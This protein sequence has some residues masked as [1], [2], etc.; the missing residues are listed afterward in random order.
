LDQTTVDKIKVSDLSDRVNI[1]DMIRSVDQDEVTIDLTAPLVVGHRYIIDFGDIRGLTG[2]F[3]FSTDVIIFDVSD[4]KNVQLLPH[5]SDWGFEEE[6]SSIPVNSQFYI[7][8]SGQLDYFNCP[9][10]NAIKIQKGP[11]EEGFDFVVRQAEDRSQIVITPDRPFDI[12]S[13]YTVSISG[14]CDV[15]GALLPDS[16]RSFETSSSPI[17]D[18]IAE[19][20]P[21]LVTG[22]PSGQSVDPSSS[23]SIDFDEPTWVL[24]GE[25]TIA[26][27][28]GFTLK[29]SFIWNPSHTR[30]TFTPDQPFPSN[31][32]IRV[33]IKEKFRF[34]DKTLIDRAGNISLPEN[35]NDKYLL[36][37]SFTIGS[38]N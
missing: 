3:V 22:V 20:N 4:S 12:S 6:A 11:I 38:A 8:I 16:T 34:F 9:I 24:L 10:K 33:R 21:R 15:S 17:F 29:G 30:V 27:S 35:A 14:L 18:K 31:R 23:I 2:Q 5:V 28:S 26:I 25:N 37:T 13:R 19:F 7:E 32:S 1:V 36:D